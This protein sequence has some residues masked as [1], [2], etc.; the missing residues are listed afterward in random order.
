MLN[1]ISY[2]K[3]FFYS[4]IRKGVDSVQQIEIVFAT[5][6]FSSFPFRVF[7]FR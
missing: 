1:N 3:V 2:F 6:S 4:W 5:T 7:A